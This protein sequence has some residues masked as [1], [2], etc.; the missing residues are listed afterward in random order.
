LSN[1]SKCF[2]TS[3][4]Q[5]VTNFKGNFDNDN[6]NLKDAFRTLLVG[7]KDNSSSKEEFTNSLAPSFFILVKSFITKLFVGTYTTFTPS[8][9]FTSIPVQLDCRP[10]S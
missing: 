9:A 8:I 10:C 2:D 1:F 4:K 5:Y 6:N 7:Y 3:Y